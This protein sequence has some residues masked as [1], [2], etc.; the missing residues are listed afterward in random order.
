MLLLA[1]ESSTELAGVALADE[2][3]IL[4]SA[5]L[6]RGRRHAETIAPCIAFLC[7]RSGVS[8]DDLDGLCV[9]VGPGLFTGLRVGISTAKGLGLALGIPLVTATSLEVLAHAAAG[10]G[11]GSD[12][13]QTSVIAVVD[14]RRKEVFHATYLIGGSDD[15]PEGDAGGY[16]L[17]QVGEETLSTP[18]DLARSLACSDMGGRSVIMVGDGALRYQKI[19]SPAAGDSVGR[20]AELRFASSDLKWPPVGVLARLGTARL[21]SGCGADPSAVR[22]LYLRDA[23]VRINWEQRFPPR[24][25]AGDAGTAGPPA[26]SP[27]MVPGCSGPNADDDRV[28]SHS[29]ARGAG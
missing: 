13:A 15:G 6:S 7:E 5:T 28:A 2:E 20:G 24:P 9:D 21:A 3:G 4:A 12:G 25:V 26:G 19:L 29:P 22:A 14:A 17:T 16:L 10:A 11:A 1:L 27:A 18:R 23:D 8:L